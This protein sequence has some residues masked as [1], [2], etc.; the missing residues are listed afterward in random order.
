M[1]IDVLKRPRL[2]VALIT[3]IWVGSCRLGYDHQPSSNN[4][5]AATID[6]TTIDAATID[7]ATID[8]TTLDAES[9]TSILVVFLTPEAV[10]GD[11]GGPLG[12]DAFCQQSKPPGLALTQITALLCAV[13]E[14]LST[15]PER[16]GYARDLPIA[17]YRHAGPPKL[18]GELTTFA[19]DWS[20]LLDGEIGH[21]GESAT[22]LS[23]EVW[24]GCSRAGEGG[25]TTAACSYAPNQCS[26]GDVGTNAKWSEGSSG[27]YATQGSLD[28]TDGN[29]LQ[30]PCP[31]FNDCSC[32]TLARVMCIGHR[33]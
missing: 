3:I 20:D 9:A 31:G 8:A 15:L 6:A 27:F 24:T 19:N 25:V 33:F 7:A 14:D 30:N 26:C 4:S 22:G 2:L 28:A 17:W 18:I 16:A 32:E 29:W 11:L 1:C 13:D 12:A 23:G 5:D 10:T 21:S